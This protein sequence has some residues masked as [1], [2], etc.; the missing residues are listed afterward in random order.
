M[1]ENNAIPAMRQFPNFASLVFMQDGA[2]AH[3]AL[4]VHALLD[5]IF[6][7]RW[8]GYGSDANPA[9]INW[10]PRR[11]DLTWMDYFC[12]SY[13]KSKVYTDS[14]YANLDDLRNEITNQ[15]QQIPSD[16]VERAVRDFVRRLKMCIERNGRSVET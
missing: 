11:P 3:K 7:N 1:L 16:V 5:Q 13:I 15:I 6:P 8:I 2:P 9:P 12:W 14:P 4:Q 10:P